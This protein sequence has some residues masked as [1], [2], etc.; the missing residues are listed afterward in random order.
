[1]EQENAMKPDRLAR[2]LTIAICLLLLLSLTACK[3][4]IFQPHPTIVQPTEDTGGLSAAESATLSSLEKLDDYPLY[5]MNYVGDYQSP[6]TSASLPAGSSF[7]CSLFASLADDGDMFYGRNFDWEFSPSLLLFT[8]PT[9]GYASVSMVNLSFLRI[10]IQTA[11]EL[12]DLPL[13]ERTTLL[14]APWTPT[15]GMNEYGLAIAMAAVPDEFMDDAPDDPSLPTIDSLGIMR[16]LLDHARDV[17]EAVQLFGSYNIDFTGGPPVHYLLADRSGK[18]VLVEFYQGERVELLNQA[19]FHLATN[20]MRCIA[21]GDGG[22]WR[23][24]TLSDRLSSMGGHLD[25]ASAMQLLSDVQ[26]EFTQWSSL[27]D[28]T[29]GDVHVVIDRDYSTSY[30]FHLDMAQP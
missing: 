11:M 20:H 9:D 4:T 23:Y 16:Q 21:F 10:S 26:Q 30:A 28:I 14:A 12:T 25:T 1:M 29:S 7:A 15:D 6:W 24:R 18:A 13:T 17:D 3:L 27:Y 2:F 8:N 19:P 22:C 5:V